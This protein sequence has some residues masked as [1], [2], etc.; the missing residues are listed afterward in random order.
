MR[1]VIGILTIL[2]TLL[3]GCKDTNSQLF[4]GYSYGDFVYLSY[5][6]SEKVS[7]IYVEKGE[8]V[9][10]GERLVKM[11][12]F[13][14]EN[15]KKIAEK[16]YR[17]EVSSLHNMQSGER[18]E[19]LDLI[20]AQLERAK[21]ALKLAKSQ[22]ERYR[23]LYS[24]RVVSEAEW[25]NFNND[26]AQKSAQVKE[27]SRQLVAKNLPARDEQIRNQRSRV[28]SAKLQLDKA[29]WDLQ[30]TFISAPQDALIYDVIYRPGERPVAGRPIISLLP[31]ENIKIRFFFPESTLAKFH[32]GM[33]VKI[34]S[35]GVHKTVSG[36][37]NY[38]SPQA[39]YTP[40]VIYSTS[41]R[42]KLI[43]MVEAIPDINQAM[44]IRIGQ[45]VRVE[46]VPHE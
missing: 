2:T 4:P 35:D 16:N 44:N 8:T 9:K 20:R 38:I 42:E 18:P 43:F 13:P 29:E 10:K 11:D 21:A 46:P 19:E 30:Q 27:L 6:M 23:P 28:E 37:I 32:V 14:S 41:R 39:E 25:D 34:Y 3:I 40:P 12:D 1:F 26:F 31:P 7:Q 36:K 24:K 33:K 5:N 17:A 22:L 45:P 15:A